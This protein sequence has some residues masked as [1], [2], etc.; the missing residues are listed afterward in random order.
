MK[1]YTIGHSAHPIEK[2]IALLKMHEIELL[3]DVRSTPASRFHPQFN[4]QR[5]EQS[6]AA[7]GVAYAYL[8]NELGG[9][10]ADPAL[11][12]KELPAKKGKARPLANFEEVMKRDW[13]VH[14]I[15]ELLEIFPKQTT[16][17][18]CSEEDPNRCH[19]HLLIGEY[20]NRTQP[21]IDVIHIRGDGSTISA[22]ALIGKSD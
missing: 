13:F 1:L 16:A 18:L 2:F 21:D 9:R 15:Q 6:L 4:Q 19:R 10:P 12:E 8:G 22:N 3:V 17:I 20:L 7:E 5:L 11:Y 14:G